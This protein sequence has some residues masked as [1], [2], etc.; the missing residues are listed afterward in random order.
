MVSSR[1]WFIEFEDG[2]E[3]GAEFDHCVDSQEV[4]DFILKEH[5]VEIIHCWPCHKWELYYSEVDI[6]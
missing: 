3:A 6:Y 5:G 4:H 1:Y 2:T